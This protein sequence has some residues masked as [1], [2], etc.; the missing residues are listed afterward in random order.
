MK[1]VLITEGDSDKLLINRLLSGQGVDN[2]NIL[3]AGGWS[4]ADSLARSILIHGDTNVA[5]V[6]DA[7]SVDPIQADE[8]QRFIEASLAQI[9]PYAEKCV[10]VI[11]PTIEGL[12]LE[13]RNIINKL[14]GQNIDRNEWNTLKYDANLKKTLQEKSHQSIINLYNRLQSEDLEPIRRRPDIRN[15]LSFLQEHQNKAVA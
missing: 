3:V 10:L 13:D 8:R 9:D 11:S 6:V 2:V 5:V 1:T 14:L 12:L 4:S 15:L 7:D